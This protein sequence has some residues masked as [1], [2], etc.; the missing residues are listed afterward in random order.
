METKANEFGG[1]WTRDKIEV[2]IKYAKAY[3]TIMKDR[4][5]YKLLYFDGFAGSGQIMP[6]ANDL[7]LINSAAVEILQIDS[8]RSFDLYYFVEK[9]KGNADSLQKTIATHF[10]QKL[11]VAH[12][13][14][15]D[16]NVKIADMA[17]FL[18]SEK[19]K[20]YRTLAFLDP[21]GM[22]IN[23]ATV[24]MLRGLPMDVWMLVPTAIG[25]GRQLRRDAQISEANMDRL[26]QFFDLPKEE[27]MR[28]FYKEDV[29]P[30]FPELSKLTKESDI[31][32]KIVQLYQK[33][34]ET[35][36]KTVSE[37]LVMRNSAGFIMYHFM[38]CTNITSANRIANDIVKKYRN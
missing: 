32:H 14:A 9:N 23:W 30:L 12:V 28:T 5:Y 16:C 33:R 22:Q 34:L 38:L 15:E 7:D 25:V 4:P 3:L 35:V 1:Q 17:E 13:V 24:E 18:N 10:P 21:Y 8:P 36:F 2:F 37:P 11:R 26:V 27:L 6:E 29:T 31:N 20:K 19:G